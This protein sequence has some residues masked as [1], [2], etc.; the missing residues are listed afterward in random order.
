MTHYQKLAV[1]IFRIIGAFFSVF[2]AVSALLS[3]T[4]PF[5]GFHAGMILM[6]LIGY[7]L[8]LLIFGAVFWL[9]S[10]KLARLVCFDLNNSDEK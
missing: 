3:L 8:P 6:F 1:M 10:K 2:S 7:S 4:A 5:F 9:A